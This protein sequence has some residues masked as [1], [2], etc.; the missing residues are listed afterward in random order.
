MCTGGSL[1]AAAVH[2]PWRGIGSYRSLRD[3]F[4][5]HAFS[6]LILQCAS[7]PLIQGGSP[8]PSA[9]SP[10]R[11]SAR[12]FLSL[13]TRGST[14][15]IRGDSPPANFRCSSI[16]PPCPRPCAPTALRDHFSIHASGSS[17][18]PHENLPWDF[19]DPPAETNPVGPSAENFSGW[20]RLP[21]RFR[22]R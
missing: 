18:F 3:G 13:P 15:S 16:L 8:E 17:A 20:P 21:A 14:Q 12:R 11:R 22:P 2:G 6:I 7:S 19:P 1:S 4:Q 5:L 9:A 10:A